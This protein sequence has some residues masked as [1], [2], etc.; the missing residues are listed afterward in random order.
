M[1][2]T[3]A[4][5]LV[6]STGA[7]FGVSGASG[8]ETLVLDTQS[9]WRYSLVARPPVVRVGP[10]LKELGLNAY[11]GVW[12]AAEGS[13]D[14]SPSVRSPAPPGD[15]TAADFDDAAW[16]RLAGPFFPSHR[17][18]AYCK[19]VEDAG[20]LY[21]ESTDPKMAVL[22]LRGKF[23]VTDP[24][25][26]GEM[27]LAVAYRGGMAVYLNGREIARANIPQAEKDR[28]IE[29]VAD[30]YPNEAF[31]KPDGQP[32]SWG[33]GDPQ[34][35]VTQL[36]SRVRRLEGVVLPA[37]LLRKGVNVLALEAH[38]APY[39]QCLDGKTDRGKGYVINWVPMGVTEVKLTAGGSGVTPNVG[40]PAGLNVWTPETG[41]RVRPTDC[42]DPCEA[43]RPLRLSG[44]R[45]GAFSGQVV[46][47]AA[48]ALRD[49]KAVPGELTGPGTIPA[50]AVQV[51]Y[52]VRDPDTGLAYEVLSPTAPTEVVPEKGG[53]ALLPVWITVAVPRDAKPGD[54]RGS[55][56]VTA[57]GA[58]DVT[59]PVELRVSDFVLPDS[60]EFVTHVGLT[61]SPESVALRYKAPL[62]SN[63][64]WR[65]IER[66]F[67]LL[68]QAGADDLYLTA[69]RRTHFGNEHG[70]IRWIKSGNTLT[71]DLSIAEKYIDLA[72]KHLGKVPVVCLYAWEPY[73]GGS[74]LGGQARAGSG[75]LYT[76]FDP[77][78]GRTEEAEGPTWGAPE[79]RSFWKPV[80]DGLRDILKKRGMENSLM[81]GVAGDQ[82]PNRATVDDLVAI[83]PQAKWVVHTHSFTDRLFTQPV[84]YI[85]DVWNAPVAP[86][87][88]VKRLY[89]WQNPLLRATFPRAGSNTVGDI[90]TGSPLGQYRVA[91]EGMNAAGI[92][93]FGRMGADFWNVLTGKD[94]RNTYTGDIFNILGRYPES[95]WAQLY[96]GN[97]TPY[98]LAPGPDGA[99]ATVRFEMI[100][101]GA[102]E[103]ECRIFLEKALVDP[104]HRAQLGEDL[105]RRCQDALDDRT[106][107]ILLARTSWYFYSNWPARNERLYALAAEAAKRL[108]GG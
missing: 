44:A 15:W 93:G 39:A 11:G 95:S 38:R 90:R 61:Q 2:R 73:T 104:A 18:H 17:G 41:V 100:R 82:R 94:T 34:R 107:A 66:S 26:A 46:A 57:A 1:Q 105:A 8:A 72:V 80:F 55:V 6:A 33:F 5:M 89:G 9:I 22:C 86:D 98:V 54:Y 4:F 81:V 67:E 60:K 96:L 40:R 50:S 56:R 78:T 91:L 49:L 63:E 68:G 53:G 21:F 10:E 71:P 31:V 35:C 48:D 24:A 101:E 14:L 77:A 97:S 102:Q 92:H 13:K 87:P 106:R 65:L 25:A 16:P 64:H 32:I 70:M 103:T 36:K 99:L 108:G 47:G 88:A 69:L 76:V 79:V 84:G 28:G 58:T 29:A 42:G 45:N 3:W 30:D 83:A 51:R 85:A 52:A 23:S 20:Y 74:Y 7:L 43:S 62:W 19:E 59:V 12:V 27:R 37:N 75:M